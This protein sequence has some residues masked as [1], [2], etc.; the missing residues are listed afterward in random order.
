MEF[1]V[2]KTG[3]KQYR[4]SPG[5]TLLVEKLDYPVGTEFELSEVLLWSNSSDT[6]L[7]IGKPF[8]DK[9]KVTAKLVDHIKDAKKIIFKYSNKTRYRKKKGHRQPLSKILIVSIQNSK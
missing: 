9:T 8:V 5:D 7:A 2:I 6:T 4:V 1:A 3:G